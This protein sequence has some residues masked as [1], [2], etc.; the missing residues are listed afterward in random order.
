[1]IDIIAS[2]FVDQFLGQASFLSKSSEMILVEKTLAKLA[3]ISLQWKN[4]AANN[5]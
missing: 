4:K 3:C 2:Y 5:I 1:M